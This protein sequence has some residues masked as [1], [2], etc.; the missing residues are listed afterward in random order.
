MSPSGIRLQGILKRYPGTVAV[1]DVDFECERGEAH[2][3]EP[4][5]GAT[6]EDRPDA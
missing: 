5:T 3:L 4:D 1:D 2:A 6:S